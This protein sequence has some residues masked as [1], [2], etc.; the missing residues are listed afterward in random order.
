MFFH[1]FLIDADCF[2]FFSEISQR[3]AKFDDKGGYLFINIPFITIHPV[4]IPIKH[5]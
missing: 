4:I 2:F 5:D 3:P 1:D